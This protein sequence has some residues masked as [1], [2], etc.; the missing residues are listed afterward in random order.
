MY[1]PELGL[2]NDITGIFRNTDGVIF[3]TV[4]KYVQLKL[5]FYIHLSW[6]H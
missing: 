3:N 6:S 5:E 2:V 4:K 1:F